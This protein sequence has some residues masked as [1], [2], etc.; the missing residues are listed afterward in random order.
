MLHYSETI[1]ETRCQT[2]EDGSEQVS[3]SVSIV[4]F[5]GPKALVHMFRRLRDHRRNRRRETR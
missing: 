3:R 1:T 2:L 4:K 5:T